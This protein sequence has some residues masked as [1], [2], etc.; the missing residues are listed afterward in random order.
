M[1]SPSTISSHCSNT[2]GCMNIVRVFVQHSTGVSRVGWEAGKRLDCLKSLQEGLTM[3]STRSSCCASEPKTRRMTINN[4]QVNTLRLLGV[5]GSWVNATSFFSISSAAHEC[6]LLREM[7]HSRIRRLVKASSI[8]WTHS[9]NNNTQKSINTNGHGHGN[10]TL[11]LSSA[12]LL[13]APT[14]T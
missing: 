12:P 11:E 5:L 6:L 8:I 13:V 9:P 3:G 7:I 2:G 14:L 4:N 1:P 10:N